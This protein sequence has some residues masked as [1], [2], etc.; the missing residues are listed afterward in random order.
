M[1]KD[2]PIVDRLGQDLASVYSFVDLC[3]EQ[4]QTPHQE[5]VHLALS[6]Q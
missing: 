2:A 5:M 6:L 4:I 1:I 3:N